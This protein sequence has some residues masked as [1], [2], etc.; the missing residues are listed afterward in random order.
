[1]TLINNF[2]DD[3]ATI[4][5]MIFL[6]IKAN[7]LIIYLNYVISRNATILLQTHMY[8]F[9]KKSLILV[10]TGIKRQSASKR[11][12]SQKREKLTKGEQ[13][14]DNKKKDL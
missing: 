2:L 11:N 5:F 10:N 9:K 6:I 3:L 12:M 7:A 8:L 13:S 1:M 4:G 14:M